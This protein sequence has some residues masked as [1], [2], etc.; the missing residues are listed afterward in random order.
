ML[1]GYNKQKHSSCHPKNKPNKCLRSYNK[2][3][4]HNYT[5]T[6]TQEGVERAPDHTRRRQ[7][8]H[9]GVQ[10]PTRDT[11]L[12]AKILISRI[13]VYFPGFILFM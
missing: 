6:S 2:Q 11:R 5:K 13:A 10:N 7:V 9:V 4:H 3:N 8:I 12:S 1:D